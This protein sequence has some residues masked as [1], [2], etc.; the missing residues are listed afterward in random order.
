M[1]EPNSQ[2]LHR[3]R[4]SDPRRER[5]ASSK[6]TE[7]GE[8]NT[9]PEDT[10]E[11]ATH[12]VKSADPPKQVIYHQSLSFVAVVMAPSARLVAHL[13][14][15]AA[16]M[17]VLVIIFVLLHL[18]GVLVVDFF[19]VNGLATGAA[20]TGDDVGFGDGFQVVFNVLVVCGLDVSD[21]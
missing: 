12:P 9:C 1:H 3:E 8:E 17:V 15:I 5:D 21:E 13:V 14:V 19:P 18:V 6:S 2:N 11:R 7:N 10:T 20:A 16:A 4:P